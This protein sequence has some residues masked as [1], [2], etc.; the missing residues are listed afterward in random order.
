MTE[1]SDSYDNIALCCKL[2]QYLM[3]TL[4]NR[5][6]VKIILKVQIHIFH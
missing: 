2:K 6:L 5:Y 4:L 3:R 1:I